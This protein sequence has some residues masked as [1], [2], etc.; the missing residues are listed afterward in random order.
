NKE[1]NIQQFF[2]FNQR[3]HQVVVEQ[4]SAFIFE[5]IGERYNHFLIDEFQ[6]TSILQWQNILPLITDTIDYGKSL[7]VGDGKQSIYRWRAGD[8]KQFLKLPTIFKG[9]HLKFKN[10]WERKLKLHTQTENLKKNF[11]SKKEIIKFNNQFF[12]ITKELLAP[13]MQDIYIELEQEFDHAINGGYIHLELFGDKENNFKD[14]ILQR[15]IKEI[16]ILVSQNNYSYRD[17]AIL[18]NSHKRVSLVAR[19]LTENGI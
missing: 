14:L 9:E 17:I 11:R 5:R 13:E 12:N 4:P 10:D 3:I 7:I 18:C 19:A 15:I 6:D 2:S 16:K 8:V 1:Q